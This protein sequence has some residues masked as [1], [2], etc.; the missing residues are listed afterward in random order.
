MYRAFVK[1][2]YV[3]PMTATIPA[4][5][6]KFSLAWPALLSLF[7]NKDIRR[8]LIWFKNNNK[9]RHRSTETVSYSLKKFHE[10]YLFIS[11]L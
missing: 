5:F 9:K 8:K 3:S 7:G 2:S 11:F 4:F 1:D 6:G 10:I